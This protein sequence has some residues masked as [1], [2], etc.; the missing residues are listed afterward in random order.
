MQWTLNWFYFA[1]VDS[2]TFHLS[3]L[4]SRECHHRARHDWCIGRCP[5][6]GTVPTD[7]PPS[8][9]QTWSLHHSPR[10]TS[11]NFPANS[12]PPNLYPHRTLKATAV[13]SFVLFEWKFI[14]TQ[15][16]CMHTYMHTY[17]HTCIGLHTYIMNIIKKEQTPILYSN[18]YSSFL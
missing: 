3:Y 8:R 5:Y 1:Y 16:T 4:H 6:S 18:K 11:E 13:Q 7:T 10:W 14:Y 15:T 2:Q 17:T 9:R 12:L